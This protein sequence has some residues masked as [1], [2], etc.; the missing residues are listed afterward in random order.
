MACRTLG[1]PGQAD[2]VKQHRENLR[3]LRVLLRGFIFLRALCGFRVQRRQPFS[4][5]RHDQRAFKGTYRGY[6]IV[7]MA[8]PSSGGVGVIEI[9]NV[10]E[11]IIDAVDFGMNAQESVDAVRLHH[12]WLPDVIN[13]E[14]FG[15]SPD[16]IKKLERRGHTL[17]EGGGQGAAQVIIYNAQDDMLEGG[18]DRR[19]A[20]GAAACVEKKSN[21]GTRGER[22]T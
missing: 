19:A 12:Q 2:R 6:D 15:L 22:R 17:R 9:L 21:R 13:Y 4:T 5:S 3:V 16:S 14:R 1:L 20:D 10:L 7:S 11:T 8:P 18:N